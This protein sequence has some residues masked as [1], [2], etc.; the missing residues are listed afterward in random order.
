MSLRITEDM[1]PEKA[2]WIDTGIPARY[3]N[4]RLGEIGDHPAD[5]II[6]ERDT[7]HRWL[8]GLPEQQRLDPLGLPRHPRDFGRGLL[9]AGPPGTGK[10]TLACAV[11]C[12]VRRSK[13]S[14]FFT[15]WPDYVDAAR[16]LMHSHEGDEITTFRA[17]RIVD[18]AL[19]A[20]FVVL[21]DVGHERTTD[22]R[23]AE[24]RLEQLLRTRFSA[25]RPTG[26]TTNLSGTDWSNRYSPALR[27][28]MA[29]AT[30]TVAV[31]GPDL[32][33]RND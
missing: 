1:D 20:Y 10:T 6:D 3:R 31:A 11:A 12:E 19:T 25:G 4:L 27:S 7:V 30:V 22:T 32:R 18:R 13:H 16:F 15:R 9:L 23:Y 2:L 33:G 21:D 8:Q 14:V 5:W 29:E 17:S 28:F 24:D 26:I